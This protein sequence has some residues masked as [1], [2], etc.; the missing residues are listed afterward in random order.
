MGGSARL[1]AGLNPPMLDG[2]V[3]SIDLDLPLFVTPGM[4]SPTRELL[5]H[6]LARTFIDGD[7]LFRVAMTAHELLENAAKY[8]SDGHARLR[9]EI[10]P[11]TVPGEARVRVTLTNNTSPDNIAIL[12]AA[13]AEME[14]AQDAQAHYFALMRRNA[15]LGSISRLG[16]ARVRAEG[17]M[18]ITLRIDGQAVTIVASS[19]VKTR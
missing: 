1:S 2:N 10:A 18:E 5:E 9:V 19:V 13:I 7:A 4:V 12:E 16:L 14:T 6:K 3:T 11:D 8:A 17:E 15:K